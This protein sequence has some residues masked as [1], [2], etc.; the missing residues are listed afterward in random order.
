MCVEGLDGGASFEREEADAI[1]LQREGK[2]I[3]LSQGCRINDSCL[4][5]EESLLCGAR[6][7]VDHVDEAVGGGAH[8]SPL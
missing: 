1:V 7:D 6:V 8:G 5:H 3:F 2:R 4:I